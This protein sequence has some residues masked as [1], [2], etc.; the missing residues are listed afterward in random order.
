LVNRIDLIEKPRT[1]LHI[2]GKCLAAIL[3]RG[4]LNTAYQ[5]Y[6]LLELMSNSLLTELLPEVNE[7]NVSGWSICTGAG[8]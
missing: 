6:D 3:V 7:E 4:Q 1:C 5:R 2:R 8:C